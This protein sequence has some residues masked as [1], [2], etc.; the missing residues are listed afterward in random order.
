MSDNV[1]LTEIMVLRE[2]NQELLEMLKDISN[3]LQEGSI[4]DVYEI[5]ELIKKHH[6]RI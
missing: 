4:P 5:D 1:L 6:E 2:A 3:D